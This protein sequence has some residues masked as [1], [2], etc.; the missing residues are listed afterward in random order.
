MNIFLVV[1]HLG[2]S[3]FPYQKKNTPST[4]WV[5]F[6]LVLRFYAPDFVGVRLSHVDQ[7]ICDLLFA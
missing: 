3:A 7:N 6:S 2:S 4:F 1:F 5:A